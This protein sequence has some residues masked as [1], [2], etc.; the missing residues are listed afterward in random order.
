M[1]ALL[2]ALAVGVSALITVPHVSAQGCGRLRERKEWRQL[3][4]RERTAYISAVRSIHSGPKPTIYDSIVK[5]HLDQA[6]TTHT[7]PLFFPFHR[8][9]IRNFERELQK[10]D[11]SVILAYWDWSIDSQTPSNSPVWNDYGHSGGEGQCVLDGSFSGWQAQYNLNG[12]DLHCLRRAWNQGTSMGS[13]FPPEYLEQNARD[14]DDYVTFWNTL[15]RGPHG[16]VHAFI[17]GDMFDMASPNDPIFWLHHTFLDKLWAEW[18][19][20]NA[21]TRLAYGGN[22]ADGSAVSLDDAIPGFNVSVRDVMDTR[23]SGYCY[24]Y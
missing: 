17:G 22:N 20:K 11:P 9:Y 1:K 2:I 8:E 4:G 5:I 10:V 13:V 12:T 7:W 24:I 15:E 21:N 23:N 19:Q 6:P 3:S 14:N 18:Q 16:I